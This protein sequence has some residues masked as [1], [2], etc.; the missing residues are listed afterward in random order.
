MCKY[1]GDS[2]EVKYKNAF[3]PKIAFDYRFLYIWYFGKDNITK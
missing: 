3:L 2:F 1:S